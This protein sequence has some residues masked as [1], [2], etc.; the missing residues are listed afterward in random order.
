MNMSAPKLEPRKITAEE[1]LTKLQ[2]TVE[3]LQS[4]I[5]EM[6]GDI[7]RLDAKFD[8]VNRKFDIKFDDV[9][10]TVDAVKDWVREGGRSP[11][12]L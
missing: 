7:R 10:R 6:K 3:W 8:E 1:R 11:K 9:N 5:S 2:V 12:P 4:H